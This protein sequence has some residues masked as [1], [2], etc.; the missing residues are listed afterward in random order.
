MTSAADQNMI[1]YIAARLEWLRDYFQITPVDGE[2]LRVL[3]AGRYDAASMQAVDRSLEEAAGFEC[4]RLESTLTG[5]MPDYPY[6]WSACENDS[7]DLVVATHFLEHLEFPWM[8]V[9]EAARVLS[10]GG[11][12]AILEPG[13]PQKLGQTRYASFNLHGELPDC[14]RFS[15]QALAALAQYSGLSVRHASMNMATPELRALNIGWRGL[16]SGTWL[17][18]EKTSAPRPRNRPPLAGALKKQTFEKKTA[19][20]V[21]GFEPFSLAESQTASPPR[22]ISRPSLRGNKFRILT[23][24]A[25]HALALYNILKDLAPAC[26]PHHLFWWFGHWGPNSFAVNYDGRPLVKPPAYLDEK[27]F[28]SPLVVEKYD[29][30]DAIIFHDHPMLSGMLDGLTIDKPVII[31]PHV[32]FQGFYPDYL[33]APPIPVVGRRLI[34]NTSRIVLESYLRGYP[35]TRALDLFR[36][37]TYARLGY[38]GLWAQELNRL[39]AVFANAGLNLGD[40]LPAWRREEPVFMYDPHH[41][42]NCVLMS[43]LKFQIKKAGLPFDLLPYVRLPYYHERHSGTAPIYPEI[44]SHLNIPEY[45]SYYFKMPTKSDW[46]DS[47]FDTPTFIPLDEFIFYSYQIY[48]HAQLSRDQVPEVYRLPLL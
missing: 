17:V 48:K 7:Q 6:D 33:H 47:P 11:L 21:S 46:P 37:E 43:L 29:H 20:P 9:S 19:P 35:E 38:Y 15:P 16:T 1:N 40:F 14:Y 36:H 24:G 18:A 12:V 26:E 28:Q 27:T 4:R 22:I 23:V 2:K 42:K 25:C 44:A 8:A 32:S 39:T 31:S 3:H 34:V 30:C 45:G 5:V 41:P 10:P 13:P